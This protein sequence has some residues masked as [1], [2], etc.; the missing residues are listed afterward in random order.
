MAKHILMAAGLVL[1]TAPVLAQQSWLTASE[2]SYRI[3]RRAMPEVKVSA[4]T[5]PGAAGAASAEPI[6]LLQVRTSSIAR[7][8]QLIHAELKH[9]GGFMQHPDES[10]GRRALARHA[11]P[12]V[13][14]A[15]RPNYE[16]GNQ[17]LVVP[18]LASMEEQPIAQAIQDLSAFPDRYYSSADGAR[19]SSWLRDTWTAL[20]VKHGNTKVELYPHA[21]YGQ[22]SVIATIAGGDLAG[23]VIVIGAHLDSI[24]ISLG[25]NRSGAPGADDD[26]SGVAAMTEVLRV[27]AE[28]RYA[29]RRTIKLIAYAAEEV[30][31]RGSQDI[32]RAFRQSETQVVGV[33]QL[34]MTNFKGSPKDIYLLSD[35]TDAA[36]NTFLAKLIETYLPTLTVGIDRCG[37]ACSDH[38]SWHAEGYPSSMPF[39]SALSQDNPHIHSKRDT[40]ANTGNQAAHALKFARLAAAFALE[41]GGSAP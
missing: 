39:E 36:Q 24:N 14:L 12:I 9:C 3:L 23:D 38:A 18:A 28:T 35:Y 31:L 7:L 25:G 26:A 4:S 15:P 33:L 6:Y 19:A 11:A 30:G 40:Y 22:A 41:L 10:S 2:A 37:Y 13:P 8:S 29:P 34:D 32:A 21:G 17:A 1:A 20:A 16:I 27:I 5:A